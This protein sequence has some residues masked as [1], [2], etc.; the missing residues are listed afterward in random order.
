[1]NGAMA[2]ADWPDTRA[3]DTARRRVPRDW[4]GAEHSR[5]VVAAGVDWHVQ[6]RGSGPL[7]VLLHGAGA[8]LHSW[9]LL[10]GYLE[11]HYQLLM[12]DLPGHGF[13]SSFTSGAY[14][15]PRTA[16]ALASL[17]E[18]LQLRPD[19][20]IGHSA[21]GAI[22]M[23]LRLAHAD[24]VPASVRLTAINPAILPF[25]GVAGVAFPAIA[26]MVCG[27]RLLT[28]L[29]AQRAANPT[30]VERLIRGTGSSLDAEQIRLY[31]ELLRRPKHV[32]SVL[33]M[34]AGW[35]LDHLVDEIVTQDASML[36]L[37]GERDTAVPWRRTRRIAGRLANTQLVSFESL[38][39]LAHEES[40]GDI[41]PCID[42]YWHER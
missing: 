12:L 28:S 34:M 33:S 36:L 39:H 35:K 3:V 19:M 42:N 22:A 30:Q 17:L 10:A 2:Q 26:R 41:A 7:L 4:P 16:S 14:T 37:L 9:Q 25:S 8:S 23:Q 6:L 24:L 32:Q 11:R 20:L 18:A 38:G 1:M 15:L 27:S 31:Q 40:P 5:I 21:G 29:L 13:S